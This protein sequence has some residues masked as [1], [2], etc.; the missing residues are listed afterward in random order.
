MLRRM[1]YTKA[2]A[3]LCCPAGGRMTFLKFKWEETYTKDCAAAADVDRNSWVQLLRICYLQEP[4]RSPL[5]LVMGLL[6]WDSRECTFTYLGT[7]VCTV[8]AVVGCA[9]PA[10]CFGQPPPSCCLRS[11]APPPMVSISQKDGIV[12]RNRNPMVQRTIVLI[13]FLGKRGLRAST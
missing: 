12:C 9:R 1:T 4:G 5:C 11:S 2:C 3:V 13:I 8:E 7:G 10:R 6:H